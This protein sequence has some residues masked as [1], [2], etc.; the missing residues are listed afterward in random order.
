M[1]KKGQ[2]VLKKK[3]KK[4]HRFS[5]PLAGNKMGKKRYYGK[6]DYY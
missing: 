6:Q 5:A 4:I 2:E 3:L 1:K